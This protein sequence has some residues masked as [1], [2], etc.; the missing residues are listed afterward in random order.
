MVNGSTFNRRI[1]TNEDKPGTRLTY[2]SYVMREKTAFIILTFLFLTHKANC[3][4]IYYDALHLRETGVGQDY[5]ENT[6]VVKLPESA[7]VIKVLSASP[8]CRY[9]QSTKEAFKDNPFIQFDPAA[10]SQKN[11]K[12]VSVPSA[13]LSS[14]NGASLNLLSSDNLDGSIMAD[15]FSKFM[16]NRTKHELN[17]AF[18]EK[19]RKELGKYPDLQ[20]I[21]PK[22]YS[23]LSA[24]GTE[25]YLYEAYMKTLRESFKDDLSSLPLHL[26]GIIDHHKDYFEKKNELKAGLY[27]AFYIAHAF[28]ANQHPGEII[29]NYDTDILG[30]FQELRAA[31]QTLKLFSASLRSNNSTSYWASYSEIKKL[32]KDEALLKIYLGLVYQAAKNDSIGFMTG[33][34]PVYL[35]TLM[36]ESCKE[37]GLFKN[38]ITNLATRTQ[39]LEKKIN[40][41]KQISNDSL[42]YETYHAIASLTID[43]MKYAV[44]AN[45]FIPQQDIYSGDEPGFS[46]DLAQASADMAIDVQRKNYSSAIVNVTRIISSIDIS[47]GETAQKAL[48]YGSFMALVAQA[49]S[50]EEIEKAI[51]AASLPTGS[52]R[53]KRESKCNV[54]L[55]AY[56]GVFG[57]MESM[58]NGDNRKM[59]NSCG[60]TAP[61]GISFSLGK[62]RILPFIN[63]SRFNGHWSHTL[64]ISIVDIGTL[65]AFRFAGDST[66]SMPEIRLKNMISPGIFY[67]LGIPK[68]PISLNVGY[69]FGPL[70]REVT[71]R[72]KDYGDYYTRLSVS[73]CVDIP[74]LHFYTQP[75]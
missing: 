35:Y 51:E 32:V 30:S 20:S 17:I 42:F 63:G 59:P 70:L 58:K 38:Y 46:F 1:D 9:G 16:I 56:C 24:M 55:N 72:A 27:T 5:I 4:S 75:K 26:P 33:Q 60:I 8:Y 2:K 12:P 25:I 29:E 43:L 57:G 15:G 74:L 62:Q 41:L 31:F 6:P 64:L 73:L 10:P 44:Q 37:L 47:F 52:A 67:S 3:Q 53:I 49:R 18:F 28:N 19:F 54:S 61:I 50:S 65:T 36:K 48:K 71:A 14:G 45:P 11:A 7:Q 39:V 13:S 66:K 68:S 23:T 22:T 34:T 21:F 40:G 69:Q